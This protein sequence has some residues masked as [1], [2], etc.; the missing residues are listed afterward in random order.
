MSEGRFGGRD[1]IQIQPKELEEINREMY[2]VGLMTLEISAK[3]YK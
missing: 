3:N 1:S 2:Q